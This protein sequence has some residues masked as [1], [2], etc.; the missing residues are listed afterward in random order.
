MG[1][2][3]GVKG[4]GKGPEK[5]PAGLS[6]TPFR[7]LLQKSHRSRTLKKHFEQAG[8][9]LLK[10]KKKTFRTYPCGIMHCPGRLTPDG[11][12]MFLY[13]LSTVPGACCKRNR[14]PPKTRLM[15]RVAGPITHHRIQIQTRAPC[16]NS[17]H[18]CSFPPC[19]TLLHPGPFF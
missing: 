2:T 6:P 15:R 17:L 8:K 13:T 5:G 10:K 1:Q 7:V 19:Y 14:I 3:I 11:P 18:F 12:A 4:V 9:P 16:R